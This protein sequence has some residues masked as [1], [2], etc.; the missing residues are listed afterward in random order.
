MNTEKNLELLTYEQ[1]AGL[2]GLS[3]FTLRRYVSERKVPFV[4]LGGS[5]LVR[6]DRQE[7]EDWATGRRYEALR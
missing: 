4:K 6:F 1:A 3:K 2:V 5:R 7:L